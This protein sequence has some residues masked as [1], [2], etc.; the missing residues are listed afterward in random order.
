[1]RFPTYLFSTRIK[2]S[3]ICIDITSLINYLSFCVVKKPLTNLDNVDKI[4]FKMCEI[5][6]YNLLQVGR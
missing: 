6:L 3:V 5:D 4:D 1:M 2:F